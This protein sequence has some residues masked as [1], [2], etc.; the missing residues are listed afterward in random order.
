[1]EK[2]LVRKEA[3]KSHHEFFNKMSLFFYQFP[4]FLCY[5][6][7]QRQQPSAFSLSIAVAG[8]FP[9]GEGEGAHTGQTNFWQTASRPIRAAAPVFPCRIMIGNVTFFSKIISHKQEIF[10]IVKFPQMK[11]NDD[12]GME[13]SNCFVKWFIITVEVLSSY[14]FITFG[15][16]SAQGMFC[17]QENSS[18]FDPHSNCPAH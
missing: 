5:N 4:I 2:S 9:K 7:L 10:L 17:T 11:E 18:L 3:V 1:M 13:S 15:P 8:V 16:F 12:L 14:L 6:D